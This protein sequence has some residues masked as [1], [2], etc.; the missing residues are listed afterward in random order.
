MRSSSQLQRFVVLISICLAGCGG[1]STAPSTRLPRAVATTLPTNTIPPIALLEPTVTAVEPTVAP[2]Q[3]TLVTPAHPAWIAI[4]QVGDPIEG[5][6]SISLVDAD[7]GQRMDNVCSAFDEIPPAWSYDGTWLA[8]V[9]GWGGSVSMSLVNAVDPTQIIKWDLARE[10]SA[11]SPTFLAWSPLDHVLAVSIGSDV[12]LIEPDSTVQPRL[13]KACAGYQCSAIAWSPDGQRIASNN[14]EG[15]S[16]I[17]LASGDERTIADE[18]I[19][20]S[21]STPD[22]RDV[23]TPLASVA[24]S[25]DSQQIAY[26]AQGGIYVVETVGGEARRQT[27]SGIDLSWSEDGRSIEFTGP[28]EQRETMV[29][30]SQKSTTIVQQPPLSLYSTPFRCTAT[31][32]TTGNAPVL[33]L[34]T[35]E[36]PPDGP[37]YDLFLNFTRHNT[38]VQLTEGGIYGPLWVDVASP[39]DVSLPLVGAWAAGPI[40][41][42]RLAIADP[43]MRGCAVLELQTLL[44]A[45]NFAPDPI[46]GIYGPSTEA[47]VR[48]F[49][50][51]NTLTIDGIVGAETWA[52]LGGW[53]WDT[54]E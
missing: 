9:S 26:A 35:N 21:G 44:A 4:R 39:P 10:I 53:S 15:L 29:I 31:L 37:I 8:C 16:V 32:R 2:P 11:W 18:G 51:A 43:P 40:R 52:A 23:P 42:P 34:P 49:Q 5:Y 54:A 7:T 17:D 46:D 48:S 36:P 25:L 41:A 13:V 50:Q 12:Y 20:L 14:L 28:Y 30:D 19:Y 47:A 1:P 6:S 45:R 24:W 33:G 38:V 3:T 27:Y 22:T